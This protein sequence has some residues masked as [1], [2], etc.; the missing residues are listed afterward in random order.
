MKDFR[1]LKVWEKGHQLTLEI[2][3]ITARFPREELYG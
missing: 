2:Y 1:R 3:R